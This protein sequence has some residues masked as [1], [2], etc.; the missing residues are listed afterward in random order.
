M[1]RSLIFA[2]HNNHKALEVRSILKNRFDIITL[3]E[4]G[5]TEEIPEPHDTLEENALEK[6][7]TIF[8]ITKK[9]CFSEDTGL[10]VESL[11]GAPGV[12][13]ARYT[14]PAKDSKKNIEKILEQLTNVENRNAQ[15]R[16]VISLILEG[17]EYMFEGICKGTIAPNEKGKTGFG[18]DPIFI[19][20]GGQFTFAEMTEE[21]KRRTEELKRMHERDL[22]KMGK[23]G[24]V[25]RRRF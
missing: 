6:S 15:F 10:E 1:M 16:T 2:T 12:T 5:I 4:A 7:K 25:S 3:N 9:N 14:G 23:V 19:P 8:R 22:K 24:K 18:Y 21:E 13:T 11:N 17:K 20:E